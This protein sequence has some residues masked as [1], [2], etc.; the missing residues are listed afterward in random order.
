[1]A[2]RNET[3]TANVPAASPA[4]EAR[5]RTYRARDALRTLTEADTIRRDKTLMRDVK[6]EAKKV[7]RTVQ[8]SPRTKK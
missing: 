1:M 7:M 8:T 4:Y 2:R 5:E 6:A 3:K